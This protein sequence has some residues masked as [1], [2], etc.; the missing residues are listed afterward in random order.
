MIAD[1]RAVFLFMGF[2]NLLIN[3]KFLKIAAFPNAVK[4]GVKIPGYQVRGRISFDQNTIIN[5]T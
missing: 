3:I 4:T 1:K 5:I 2:V